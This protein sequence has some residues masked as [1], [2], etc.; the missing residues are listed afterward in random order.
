MRSA[1]TQAGFYP[2]EGPATIDLSLIPLSIR[3]KLDRAEIKLHLTQ[4]QKISL[5]DRQRLLDTPCGTATE[6]IAYRALLLELIERYFSAPPTSHPLTSDE[7]WANSSRW[8][9]V[10]IEQSEKQS[11][12]LPPV[13]KWQTLSEIDRHALFVLGRSKHAHEEFIAAVALFFKE[14]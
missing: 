14:A 5:D 3:Y 9:Q 11:T 2:F 8:P 13:E 7:P 12:A 10:V 6:V 4:W 1:F